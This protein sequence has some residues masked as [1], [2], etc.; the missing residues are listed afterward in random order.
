MTIPALIDKFDTAEIVRDQVA[1]ILANEIASQKALATLAAKN[2]ADWDVKVYTERANPWANNSPTANVWWDGSTLDPK[3]SNHVEH[4][5]YLATFNVDC[6]GFGQ[7]S[8]VVT[9]GHVP[10]DEHAA[11]EA[12]RVARLVRNILQA[13]EYTYL[14][15]RAV[16]SGRTITTIRNMQPQQDANPSQHVAA[17]RL[18]LEVKLIEASPQVAQETLDALGVTIK[19]ASDGQVLAQADYTT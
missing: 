8:N 19:R 3:G 4:Q 14:N 18:T 2:P 5:V 6:Y 11:K 9:G 10:G 12:Q 15:L 1:S 7:S 17:A 13:A 16:V